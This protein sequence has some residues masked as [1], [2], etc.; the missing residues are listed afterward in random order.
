MPAVQTFIR[1]KKSCEM[2][3]DGTL[4]WFAGSLLLPHW[5]PIN[6]EAICPSPPLA[7]DVAAAAID[8]SSPDANGNTATTS[9]ITVLDVLGQISVIPTLKIE[10]KTCVAHL[11]QRSK[12]ALFSSGLR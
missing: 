9:M 11:L 4:C 1:R 2:Y 8:R 7:T 12:K 10:I 3:A 6:L 5:R